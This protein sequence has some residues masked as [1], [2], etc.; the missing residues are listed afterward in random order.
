MAKIPKGSEVLYYYFLLGGTDG[1]PYHRNTPHF[2]DNVGYLGP[3]CDG[4][5]NDY[6]TYL[7]AM[8]PNP[9]K[10]GSA[11]RFMGV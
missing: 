10:Y 8:A 1:N 6:E 4:G 11:I 9:S 2:I 7:C 5:L 3:C